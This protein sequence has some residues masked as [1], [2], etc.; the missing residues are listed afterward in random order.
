MEQQVAPHRSKP[1]KRPLLF[2][3]QGVL[4]CQPVADKA[5]GSLGTYFFNLHAKDTTYDGT[6]E[7]GYLVVIAAGPPCLVTRKTE[8]GTDFGQLTAGDIFITPP[9]KELMWQISGQGEFIGAFLS[10]RYVQEVAGSL[11]MLR[12]STVIKEKFQYKDRLVASLF[13]AIGEHLSAPGYQ[14]HIYTEAMGLALCTHLLHTSRETETGSII[15]GRRT[16]SGEQMEKIRSYITAH[17]DQRILTSELA[18]C[19]HVS[20]FHFYRLF[21][22]TCGF[23]PQQFIKNIRLEKAKLLIEDS[24]LSL[25]EIAY[26][27]GFTDQS[28]LSREFRSIYSLSPGKFRDQLLYK[29]NLELEFDIQK[30]S[31]LLIFSNLMQD[32]TL[33]LPNYIPMQLLV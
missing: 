3:W 10:S 17:I 7:N 5:F 28:H 9:C 12:N 31:L 19:V 6:L 8:S 20:H 33:E 27:T 30:S 22:R 24:S 32:I 21:K 11:S 25:S 13:E 23:T 16:F 29:Q 15:L 1:S 26:K 4:P 14:D 2:P 18:D